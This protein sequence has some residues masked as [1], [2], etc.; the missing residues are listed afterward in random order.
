MSYPVRGSQE[1]SG[2]IAG[3]GVTMAGEGDEVAGREFK[4]M[5]RRPGV[6]KEKYEGRGESEV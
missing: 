2:D 6:Q 4:G 5:S 1:W 3:T